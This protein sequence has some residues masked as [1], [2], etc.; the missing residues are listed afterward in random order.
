MRVIYRYPDFSFIEGRL[1]KSWQAQVGAEGLWSARATEEWLY[2]K[3]IPAALAFMPVSGEQAQQAERAMGDQLPLKPPL[4]EARTPQHLTPYI[5]AM[6]EYYA[7]S[8]HLY[9]PAPLVRP[10]YEVMIRLA[11]LARPR[12]E[13]VKFMAGKLGIELTASYQEVLL[14]LDLHRTRIRNTPAEHPGEIDLLSRV[15]LA[16]LRDSRFQLSPQDCQAAAQ[17]LLPLWQHW[18]FESRFKHLPG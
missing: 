11:A 12:P 18:R 8:S 1:G 16:F 7:G 9:V 3:L 13:T 15:F 10:Y 2:K 6:Q 14:H 5:Q 17:A 4:V